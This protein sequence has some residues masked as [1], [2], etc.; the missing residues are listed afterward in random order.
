MYYV[1]FSTGN[2]IGTYCT[3][4]GALATNLRSRQINHQSIKPVIDHTIFRRRD[5]KSFDEEK[6]T[7]DATVAQNLKAKFDLLYGAEFS[8]VQLYAALRPANGVMTNA[9]KDSLRPWVEQNGVTIED[10]EEQFATAA[11]EYVQHNNGVLPADFIPA[12]W[13]VPMLGD[14]D[15]DAS[16]FSD[17]QGIADRVVQ[18]HP[19]ISRGRLQAWMAKAAVRAV[20]NVN[21]A[22]PLLFDGWRHNAEDNQNA[23]AMDV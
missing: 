21:A 18:Q 4:G 14:L 19:N 15:R 3:V 5:R 8:C 9:F 6:T 1:L 13:R 23:A 11:T 20:K 12:A 7:M 17:L 22:D 10:L 16:F 2:T